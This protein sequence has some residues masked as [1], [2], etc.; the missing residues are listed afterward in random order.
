MKHAIVLIMGGKIRTLYGWLLE[1]KLVFR[2][3][4]IS[5]AVAVGV[6]AVIFLYVGTAGVVSATLPL[7]INSGDTRAHVDYIWRVY[8][9]EIPRLNDG[10][11]YKPFNQRG[12]RTIQPQA[13]H[14]PLFYAL[15]APLVGPYLERGEWEKGIGVARAINVL[16][17]VLCILALAWAGWLYAGRRGELFAVALPAIAAMAHRFTSLN[18]VY[19]PDALLVL[20]TTLTFIAIYKIIKH[21]L[22]PKYLAA[23]LVL[24]VLGMSTKAGYLSILATSF[25]A[26]AA[27]AFLHAKRTERRRQLLRA[28][29][30]IGMIS[31]AVAL[32]VGWFYYVRNY[33]TTGT[34]FRATQDDYAHGRPY[35]SL[36][37]VAFGS[38]LR[39]LFYEKLAF[40]PML[41]VAI[42][43]FAVAGLLTLTRRH[44]KNLLYKD[45]FHVALSL[46]MLIAFLGVVA[47][48]IT[49]AVGYG[50][51][52]FRYLLPAIM[53]IGLVLAYGLLQF[54]SLRGQLVAAAS[55]LLG[56]ATMLPMYSVL[57]GFFEV[58][59]GF[60]DFV[61]SSA[62]NHIAFGWIAALL[63][64]FVLG[65]VLLSLSLYKISA[66]DKI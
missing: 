26:V 64:L 33:Q 49:F 14:P 48:Q 45:R 47:G 29:L 53:P 42:S 66:K 6:L 55:V 63:A 23:L 3:R 21:G 18:V 28:G 44:I 56:A 25:L 34:W 65:A 17:G 31:L 60:N 16:L 2:G 46:L 39:N 12:S 13:N 54:K 24:S 38:G 5:K 61:T 30:Y 36:V 19:G 7:D 41:S 37:Q 57:P 1:G 51:V 20:L 10:I 15:N 58:K 4:K 62:H 50:S 8:H 22:A 35:K 52:N 32:A 40:N 59:N 9:G 43:S 27:A 11:R